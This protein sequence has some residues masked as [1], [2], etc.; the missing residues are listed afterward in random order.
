VKRKDID[1][2]GFEIKDLFSLFGFKTAGSDENWR[3]LIFKTLN[4]LDD[5]VVAKSQQ[6]GWISLKN[7]L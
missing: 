4:A 6:H 2:T 1:V 5:S 7:L 3:D